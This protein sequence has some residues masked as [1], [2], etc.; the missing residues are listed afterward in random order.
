[1]GECIMGTDGT[2]EITVGF[3]DPHCIAWWYR[4]PP[5][6]APETAKAGGKKAFV[7]GATHATRRAGRD[8]PPLTIRGLE[9]YGTEKL[10]SSG[11]AVGAQPVMLHGDMECEEQH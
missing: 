2:I 1:M 3:D 9:L 11:G 8:P 5:K 4:E 6:K 10:R 7:A